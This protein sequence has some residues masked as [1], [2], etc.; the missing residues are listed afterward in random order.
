[1][2]RLHVIN[3]NLVK[4]E[5]CN[6]LGVEMQEV[7]QQLNLES[8]VIMIDKLIENFYTR[9]CDFNGFK[10]Q[11]KLF[12]NQMNI[13]VEKID[14]KDQMEVC[15]LQASEFYKSKKETGADL[16]KIFFN[17]LKP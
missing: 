7:D 4:F 17:G 5:W 15:E 13:D 10:A 11:L 12:S 9:F 2:L 1:L 16:F 14:I 3:N 6:E 8:Y